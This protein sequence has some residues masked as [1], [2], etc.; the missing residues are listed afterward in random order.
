M[1]LTVIKGHT[2]QHLAMNIQR[3]RVFSRNTRGGMY[4]C[5]LCVVTCQIER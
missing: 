5:G 1:M 2:C 3:G 4:D